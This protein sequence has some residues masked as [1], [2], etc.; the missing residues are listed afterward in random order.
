MRRR[1]SRLPP[2]LGDLVGARKLLG[3]EHEVDDG[4]RFRRAECVRGE[5]LELPHDVGLGSE[6]RFAAARRLHRLLELG[7]VFELHFDAHHVAVVRTARGD[8]RVLQHADF[9]RQRDP[10]LVVDHVVG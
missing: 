1:I 8:C 9:F 3:A 5:L 7:A 2:S 6:A 4:V 10:P